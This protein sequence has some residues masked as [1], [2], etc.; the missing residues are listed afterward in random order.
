[1]KRMIYSFLGSIALLFSLTALSMT[2]D[3]QPES[4]EEK[5]KKAFA[6][7][8]AAIIER[9]EEYSRV[10]TPRNSETKQRRISSYT[11]SNDQDWEIV[12]TN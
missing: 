9:T 12:V 3:K 4:L 7:K 8:V 5:I 11:P 6:Q 2:V 1:M 10:P